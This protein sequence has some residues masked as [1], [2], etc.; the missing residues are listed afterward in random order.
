MSI[1][2]NNK[3]KTRGYKMRSEQEQLKDK[4]EARQEHLTNKMQVKC[5]NAKIKLLE[6]K[7]VECKTFT[8][9]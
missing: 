8:N 2:Q 7:K 5:N 4:I 9:R 3:L 1:A 6:N